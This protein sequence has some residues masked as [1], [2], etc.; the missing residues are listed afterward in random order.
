MMSFKNINYSSYL[1]EMDR[2][3][4]ELNVENMREKIKEIGS[5]T[6]SR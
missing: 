3:F 6:Q 4:R 5:Y 2:K 1:S